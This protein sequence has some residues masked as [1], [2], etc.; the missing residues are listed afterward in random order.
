LDIWLKIAITIVTM[1]IVGPFSTKSLKQDIRQQSTVMKLERIVAMA[2][3]NGFALS[4]LWFVVEY[5]QKGHCHGQL[6]E[7]R[8][9]SFLVVHKLL[10]SQHFGLLT[11]QFELKIERRLEF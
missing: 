4:F 8:L 3:I 9:S 5:G 10:N 1:A 6:D 2:L 11:C 7:R